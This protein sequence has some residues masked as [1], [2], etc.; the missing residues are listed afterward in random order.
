MKPDGFLQFG[1]IELIIANWYGEARMVED[2]W[3]DDLKEYFAIW[4]VV[5]HRM[6]SPKWKG[7]TVYEILLQK[8]Q[9]SW[10]RETTPQ[11]KQYSD[12]VWMFVKNKS[13]KL[14]AK[15]EPYAHACFKGRVR[16]FSNGADHY[17]AEWLYRQKHGTNHWT[18]LYKIEAAYGGHLFF[19]SNG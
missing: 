19:N 6:D 13:N 4:G 12:D 14:Y 18:Q 1:E 16:D 15:L 11:E 17:A 5:K 7:D 2:N 8:N 9:F 10:T 3:I